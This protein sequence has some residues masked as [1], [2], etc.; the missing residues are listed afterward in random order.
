MAAAK[1]A[2]DRDTAALA[3][4]QRVT[5]QTVAAT[6]RVRSVVHVLQETDRRH[7]AEVAT[8]ARRRE[9]DFAADVAAAMRTPHAS[10]FDRYNLLQR[11]DALQ[12]AVRHTHA[13]PASPI[14]ASPA[15]HPGIDG[16]ASS[17]PRR[18]LSTHSGAASRMVTAGQL[19]LR[20]MRGASAPSSA[21]GAARNGSRPAVHSVP[22]MM[23]PAAAVDD[24]D[25]PPTPQK[26]LTP[27]VPPP[28]PVQSG[29]MRLVSARQST[30]RYKQQR[31]QH[32]LAVTGRRQRIE[33]AEL[34]RLARLEAKVDERLRRAD[35][36]KYRSRH[37]DAPTAIL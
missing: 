3:G 36:P 31:A 33:A 11:I 12:C 19:H 23:Q 1:I 35:A 6:D 37:P 24:D 22:L 5:P 14:T 10:S 30:Q 26:R 7:D 9:G 21:R 17:T 20:T 4:F 32:A 16:A 28:P 27:R 34:E 13:P 25:D 2:S 18:P 29:A 8:A 15:A